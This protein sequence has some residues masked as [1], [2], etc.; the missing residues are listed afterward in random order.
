VIEQVIG[1]DL[2]ECDNGVL[3]SGGFQTG[4]VPVA[5]PVTH[6]SCYEVTQGD[7]KPKIQLTSL[8]D[9][10]GSYTPMLTEVHRICAPADKNGEDPSAPANPNHEAAY[11][12]TGGSPAVVKSGQK[13]TNQFGTF[14]MDVR[15]IDRLFVPTAKKLTPPPPAPL[16]SNVIRHYACH[17]L[18]SVSGPDI[19]KKAVTVVDQFA[20]TAIPGFTDNS[21]WKLCVAANKN[22]E[23]PTA[24][25]DNTALLCL[26][27]ART[28]PFGTHKLFLNNQFGP[29]QFAGEPR[30]TQ[31]D[32]LCL[33]S[34]IL[35]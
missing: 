4:S 16:P 21:K 23:D 6:F 1:Y 15:G 2:A 31:F 32:E 22:N 5:A 14:T 34:T 24:P 10:Y 3:L 28:A 13:V 17:N 11:E 18:S 12:L 9:R 26:F 33:P 25:T 20:T 30:A 7:L 27:A 8:V 35:P 19:G 29:N